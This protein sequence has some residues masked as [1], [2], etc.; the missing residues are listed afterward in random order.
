MTFGHM[1][2]MASVIIIA[3][4]IIRSLALHKIP[5]RTFLALWGMALV[6][7]FV[8]F[9]FRVPMPFSVPDIPLINSTDISQI[10]TNPVSAA[11]A[12]H[13]SE[14]LTMVP[15]DATVIPLLLL[16]WMV[17]AIGLAVYFISVHIR[18]RRIY[19][20]AVP[21]E[22]EYVNTWQRTNKLKTRTVKIKVS[23][24]ISAP[25]TYGLINP[26]ILMPKTTDWENEEQ[27]QYILTHEMVHVRRFDSLWKLL[28]LLAACIHWFNP[29]V[30]VMYVLANR[31][32]EITCDERVVRALGK[33]TKMPYALTLIWLAEKHGRITPLGNAFSK[34][35]AEER[36]VSIM[37]IK[38]TSI[39]AIVVAA[40]LVAGATTVF[41]ALSAP[42]DRTSVVESAEAVLVSVNRNDENRYTPEEW[43]DI[44]EKV[45]KGEILFFETRE[46]EVGYFY[47]KT[48]TEI[49]ETM[50]NRNVPI[51]TSAAGVLVSVNRNDENRYTQ[52][53]WADILEKVET[54]EI[55]FFETYEEEFE[56]H[57]GRKPSEIPVEEPSNGSGYEKPDYEKAVT[58]D[59]D[60]TSREDVLKR[61]P[62]VDPQIIDVVFSWQPDGSGYEQLISVGAKA[63]KHFTAED[64][65][66]ILS[67]VEI[68]LVQWE[69]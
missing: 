41:A 31:D 47:G 55:L 19:R 3:T 13:L 65:Q 36:I 5:K 11:Q 32:L 67:A 27:L 29:F 1:S 44:L 4:A 48:P 40:L 43:A 9:Q 54:G 6:R 63:K 10:S 52:E 60:P 53:E 38:K 50:R 25:L 7:L 23:A 61:Y 68:G 42:A 59:G 28:L 17:V 2:L 46:E 35:A 69:D 57:H 49:I 37:K 8:P 58:P 16:V 62:Q 64:W 30:W 34:N 18:Y 15:S 39:L 12:Q 56:H 51:E 45:E 66:L 20:L 14:T 26:I 21:V 24:D 33:N 22:H